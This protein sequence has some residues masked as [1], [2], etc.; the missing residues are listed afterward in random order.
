ME[1]AILFLVWFPSHFIFSWY[2]SYIYSDEP[3]CISLFNTIVRLF[4]QCMESRQRNQSALGAP[5]HAVR[6]QLMRRRLLLHRHRKGISLGRRETRG[7][8]DKRA[9]TALI[10]ATMPSRRPINQVLIGTMMKKEIETRGQGV[11][12]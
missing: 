4:F 8:R 7:W 3:A 12:G 11:C 5:L 6:L 2:V 1:H 9:N 10:P